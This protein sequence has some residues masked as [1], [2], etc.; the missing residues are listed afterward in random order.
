[1]RFLGVTIN[2]RLV[3]NCSLTGVYGIGKRTALRMCDECGLSRT[4]KLVNVSEEAL[5][6]I[7]TAVEL[8]NLDVGSD[9]V[10][11]VSTNLD[12]YKKIN[13]YRGL[14]HKLG[15]PVR[16]QRTHTNAQTARRLRYK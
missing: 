15:L 1:M 12:H 16:G 7:K 6:S 14:R 3:V 11:K 8:A 2:D 10:K 13:C 9:L 4:L 5:G